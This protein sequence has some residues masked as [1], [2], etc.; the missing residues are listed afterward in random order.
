MQFVALNW[1]GISSTCAYATKKYVGNRED[2]HEANHDGL[3]APKRIARFAVVY[4]VCIHHLFHVRQSSC[5]SQ[6]AKQRTPSSH[7]TVR[8]PNTLSTHASTPT[9][10]P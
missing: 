7:R 1:S 10:V 4:R 2:A 6:Y 9:K 5:R 3:F 8:V